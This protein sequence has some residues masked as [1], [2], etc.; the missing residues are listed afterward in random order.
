[1]SDK[2]DD[3]AREIHNEW[4]AWEGTIHE[5]L[6]PMIAKALREAFADGEAHGKGSEHDRLISYCPVCIGGNQMA[7]HNHQ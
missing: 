5:D 7:R 1:M 3:K 4:W 6:E 2:F